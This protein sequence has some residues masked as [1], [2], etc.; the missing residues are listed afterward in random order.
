M[1]GLKK[2]VTAKR[3]LAGERWL[4][5]LE[6]GHEAKRPV[7]RRCQVIRFSGKPVV[8]SVIDP[9]PTWVY[10]NQCKERYGY[11]PRMFVVKRLE[12]TSR[13]GAKH[14]QG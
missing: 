11:S 6:C 10:C 5:R 14:E 13:A 12:G 1:R 8:R 3:E 9:A 7:K 4:L 2:K